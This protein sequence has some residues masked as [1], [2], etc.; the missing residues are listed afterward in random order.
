M[1][2]AVIYIL[3]V[4]LYQTYSLKARSNYA[5]SLS[6]S[7]LPTLPN[8][9]ILK[10]LS[11]TGS[12]KQNSKTYILLYLVISIPM[13]ILA[14]SLSKTNLLTFFTAL[15]CLILVLTLTTPTTLGLIISALAELIIYGLT[16][17]ICNSS[18][19]SILIIAKQAR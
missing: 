12:Y 15:I 16:H 5:L 10:T 4:P 9:T 11:L 19:T 1:F 6:I 18:L 17:L 2:I 13:T 3:V 8:K 7:F 14:A